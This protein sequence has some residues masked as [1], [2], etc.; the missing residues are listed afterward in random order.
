LNI[1]P[2]GR[3]VAFGITLLAPMLL[4]GRQR[5]LRG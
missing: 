1:R 2:F 4:Y 5:R 3:Q